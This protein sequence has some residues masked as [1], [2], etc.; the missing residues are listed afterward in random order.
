MAMMSAITPVGTPR[1]SAVATSAFPPNMSSTPTTAAPIHSRRC[2]R[3]HPPR[4]RLSTIRT[5]PATRN[6]IAGPTSGGIVWFDR[7]I[8]RYVVPQKK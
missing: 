8:A 5:V 4:A 3:R 6:R 1:S 7:S 2:G